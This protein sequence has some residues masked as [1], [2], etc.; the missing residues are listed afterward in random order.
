[1]RVGNLALDHREEG[2]QRVD[3][4]LRLAEVFRLAAEPVVAER[5]DGVERLQQ[6]VRD[7][8]LRQLGLQ[9]LYELLLVLSQRAL[10]VEPAPRRPLGV[11]RLLRCGRSVAR[12]RSQRESRGRWRC[13][14][15]PLPA[16]TS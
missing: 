14:L 8:E 2:D 15:A 9:L 16:A 3:G 4:E 10:W 13:S 1:G 11:S 12:P 7:L 5:R 6:Q